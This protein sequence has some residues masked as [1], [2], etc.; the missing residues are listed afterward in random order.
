[1][2]LSGED[3]RGGAPGPRPPKKQLEKIWFFGVKSW[4][5]TRNTPKI[6]A[7]PSPRCNFFKYS[8][9]TWNP[10]SAHGKRRGYIFF[11]WNK[12]LWFSSLMGQHLIQEIFE[13]LYSVVKIGAISVA[14][15]LSTLGLISS[16]PA[17][18]FGFKFRRSLAMPSQV[19]VISGIVW[20]F[21]FI[22]NLQLDSNSLSVILSIFENTDLNWSFKTFALGMGSVI[23]LPSCFNDEIPWWSVFLCLI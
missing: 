12:C 17:A 1:M 20:Y 9:L 15:S 7:P 4:F 19:M 2:L 8:P 10:G 18:L 21:D 22:D 13:Q 16:G 23:N 11:E 6:F 5:F 3:P 14:S